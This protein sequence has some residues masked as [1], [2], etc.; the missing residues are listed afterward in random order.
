MCKFKKLDPKSANITTKEL[1]FINNCIKQYGKYI[2]DD[3]APIPTSILE[4]KNNLPAN[5]WLISNFKDQLMGFVYLDNFI[6]KSG[7][8]YSAEL[9]TCFAKYAWGNFTKYCAKIFLKKCFDNYKLKKIK[10]HI[11]PDN[12]RVKK[13]LHIC[14]FRYETTLKKETLRKGKPQDIDV[15]ALYR[16][17]YYN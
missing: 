13:L 16:N 2:Q 7:F 15:F 1:L 14:G 6:G 17:Y 8:L 4:I 5:F 9:T 11:Y 12:F 3:F 10:A